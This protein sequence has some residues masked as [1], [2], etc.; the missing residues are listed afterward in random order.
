MRRPQ[1]PSLLWNFLFDIVCRIHPFPLLPAKI[2]SN[3]DFVQ[4][5]RLHKQALALLPLFGLGHQCIT[6]S[7]VTV[8]RPSGLSPLHWRPLS[9]PNWSIFMFSD[10]TTLCPIWSTACL[11]VDTDLRPKLVTQSYC[12]LAK[13]QLLLIRR[14]HRSVPKLGVGNA[15][16]DPIRSHFILHKRLNVGLH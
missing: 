10:A 6:Y 3:V 1:I 7:V 5:F 12:L 2:P 14:S 11:V 16:N 8:V 4:H 15:Q 13:V 9:L